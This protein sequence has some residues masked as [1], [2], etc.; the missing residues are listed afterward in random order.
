[1]VVYV[2]LCGSGKITCFKNISQ[3]TYY[4]LEDAKVGWHRGGS[5]FRIQS[6]PFPFLSVCLL[7]CSVCRDQTPKLCRSSRNVMK[8]SIFSIDVEYR[9]QCLYLCSVQDLGFISAGSPHLTF[10]VRGDLFPSPSGPLFSLTKNCEWRVSFPL[11]PEFRTKPPPL[12]FLGTNYRN[13]LLLLLSMQ[14][15]Q[16]DFTQLPSSSSTSSLHASF[17]SPKSEA[18]VLF[19]TVSI[20]ISDCLG[21]GCT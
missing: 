7:Y 3:Q 5:C 9:T 21:L 6:L 17:L 11:I 20:L 12:R 4:G 10:L 16:A 19:L 8:T 18:W 14:H 2:W 13:S 1:M 15:S